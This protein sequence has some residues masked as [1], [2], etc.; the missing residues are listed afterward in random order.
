MDGAAGCKVGLRGCGVA[1]A[2][3]GCTVTGGA[4]VVGA[5]GTG[6]GGI[7]KLPAVAGGDI[8]GTDVTGG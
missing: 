7:P 4:K 8:T 1:T 3:V 2:A 6:A 5:A